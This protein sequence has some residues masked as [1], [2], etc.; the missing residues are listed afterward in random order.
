M[1]NVKLLKPQEAG[2]TEQIQV[3]EDDSLFLLKFGKLPIVN[4]R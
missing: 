4:R 3:S 2:L 1:G